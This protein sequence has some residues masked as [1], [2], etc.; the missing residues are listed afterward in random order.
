MMNWLAANWA[1]LLVGLALAA[2][3]AAVVAKMIWD[4][5]HK[6]SACG[7]SCSGCAGAQYC[8]KV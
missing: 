1:S 7:C 2:I 8:H 4:K 5:K 6:K 3:V